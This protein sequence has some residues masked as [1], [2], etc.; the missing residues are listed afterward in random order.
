[1]PPFADSDDLDVRIPDVEPFVDVE[2]LQR[3]VEEDAAEEREL[4]DEDADADADSEAEVEG[5]GQ[6]SGV[7]VGAVTPTLTRWWGTGT[8]GRSP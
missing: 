7:P 6:A 2:D 1:L 8:R 5:E 4:E 3:Q